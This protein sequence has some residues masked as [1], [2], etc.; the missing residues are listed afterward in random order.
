MLDDFH[1][2]DN[3]ESS[4][5]LQERLDGRVS[6]DESVSEARIR[7]CVARRD[8]DVVWGRVDGERVGAETR[9]ALPCMSVSQD[10]N[11]NKKK[12]RIECTCLG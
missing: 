4:W 3:I 11:N 2:T 10:N 6:E 5:L 12:K 9:E 7:R 1:R 8:A